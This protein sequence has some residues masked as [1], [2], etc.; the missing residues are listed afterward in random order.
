MS[1]RIASRKHNQAKAIGVGLLFA[2]GDRRRKGLRKMLIR[3]RH[4][5]LSRV[6]ASLAILAICAQAAAWSQPTPQAPKTSRYWT[7]QDTGQ[8]IRARAGDKAVYGHGYILTTPTL[9]RYTYCSSE[10][11]RLC[12]ELTGALA[13]GNRPC[14]GG[15]P[16]LSLPTDCAISATGKEGC[17]TWQEIRAALTDLPNLRNCNGFTNTLAPVYEQKSWDTTVRR[18]DRPLL[19]GAATIIL[20]LPA[21]D[22]E[23]AKREAKAALTAAG[24][25]RDTELDF[26]VR[27]LNGGSIFTKG[28]QAAKDFAVGHISLKLGRKLLPQNKIGD[29]MRG[30]T[31]FLPEA[32][33]GRM[34]NDLH[35][36]PD[37]AP[38]CIYGDLIQR[39]AGGAR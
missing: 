6:I 29:W 30:V 11:G 1:L 25:Y 20:A 32:D 2:D 27:S 28:M 17:V 10:P 31:R 12:N 18:E 36:K 26:V 15:S 24:I 13:W 23:Q 21:K 9:T 14:T 8:C 34:I 4:G 38:N 7:L 35:R 37:L 19:V 22:Q 5:V 39:A 3:T 16:T 33:I